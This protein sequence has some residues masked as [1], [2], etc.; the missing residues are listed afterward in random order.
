MILRL[1]TVVNHAAPAEKKKKSFFE[2]LLGTNFWGP[3]SS[4]TRENTDNAQRELASYKNEPQVIL[5]VNP[6]TWWKEHWSIHPRYLCIST[7]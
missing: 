2:K 3:G 6:F 5:K 1:L 7:F 4:T